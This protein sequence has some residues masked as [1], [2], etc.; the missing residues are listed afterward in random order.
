MMLE[1]LKALRLSDGKTQEEF[2]AQFGIKKTTY[3][4]YENGTSDPRTEFWVDVADRY[5][6]SVDY[7]LGMVDDPHRTKYAAMS[8]V[9][10]RYQ[11][12]DAHGRRVVD[13]V[14]DAEAERIAAPVEPVADV[15]DIRPMIRHYLV[16]AAAGYASPVQGSD[17]EMIPLP[18]NAPAGADFCI[19]VSGDSMEPYIPDGSLAFVKRGAPLE[20]FDVGVFFV[21]GDVFVKQWCVDFRGTLYLLSANPDREDCNKEISKSAAETVV[22]FGKVLGIKKLPPPEYR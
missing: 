15:V 8:R 18:D 2:G 22:C 21:S 1:N 9:E 6:V 19:T 4:G 20:E 7:L 16:P 14:M 17:Y 13:L 5:R 11:A 12:L 10:A 3:A